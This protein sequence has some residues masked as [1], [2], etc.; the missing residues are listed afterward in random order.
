MKQ[1]RSTPT[2]MLGTAEQNRPIPKT[3]HTLRGATTEA[4]RKERQ[5]TT[6][7][8]LSVR[9]EP[10]VDDRPSHHQD[11]ERGHLGEPLRTGG[12]GRERAK[13]QTNSVWG[14]ALGEDRRG[15]LSAAPK[16]PHSVQSAWLTIARPD[17]HQPNAT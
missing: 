13:E 5:G 6:H 4:V 7:T 14:G 9:V 15:S 11:A 3:A 16:Q 17:R 2:T 12:V 10:A 8:H 1:A